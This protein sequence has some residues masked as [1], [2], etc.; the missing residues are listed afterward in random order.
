M[1]REYRRGKQ[2]QAFRRGATG[3]NGFG[4]KLRAPASHVAGAGSQQRVHRREVVVDRLRRNLGALGDHP[5]GRAEGS[6][7][8]VQVDRRAHDAL[9]GI[10]L[11][12]GATLHVV[13]AF[14]H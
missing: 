5:V 3:L 4:V 10:R 14:G 6:V 2:L 9:A 1:P 8:G 13:R 11:E 7:P 12:R